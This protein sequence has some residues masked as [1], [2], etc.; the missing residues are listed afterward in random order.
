MSDENN[1]APVSSGAFSLA[2]LANIVTTE[3]A[4]MGL[5]V[6]RVARSM[7]TLLL[8]S[9]ALGLLLVSVWFAQL[10]MALQVFELTLAQA[11]GVAM[12]ANLCGIWWL[13]RRCRHYS[14]LLSFPATRHSLELLLQPPEEH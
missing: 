11:L 1:Q 2:P 6:E 8:M 10:V 14:S 4:I 3:L 13:L 12:V 5:E 7:V 9:V